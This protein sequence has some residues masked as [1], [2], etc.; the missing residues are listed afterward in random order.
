MLQVV[1]SEE[2]FQKKKHPIGGPIGV[3]IGVSSIEESL[4]LYRDI[5]GFKVTDYNEKG[6]FPD[7]KALN[8]RDGQFQRM[9]LSRGQ[10]STGPFGPILGSCRIELV[11]SLDR[12]PCKIFQNRYWGD[13]GF[14]HLCFDV[15][16]MDALGEDLLSKGFSFTVDS[17]TPFD[18]GEAA[19]RFTYIEDADGTL[20][21]FVETRR[22]PIMK[23]WGWSIDLSR[24][25]YGKP[26]PRLILK[27]LSLGQVKRS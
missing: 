25:P 16:G 3:V 14:I 27:A 17:K 4:K 18:M 8:G 13:G 23:R 15:H 19:G 2:W 10:S 9:S 22:V 20:I 21:E 5:L 6:A 1:Q 12:Q 26:L 11:Q 7:W 24:R